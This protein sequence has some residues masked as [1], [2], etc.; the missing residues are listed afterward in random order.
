M[1]ECDECGYVGL[2]SVLKEQSII[3]EPKASMENSNVKSKREPLPLQFSDLLL[4]FEND[5]DND[6]PII[7][8]LVAADIPVL[9]INHENQLNA[10]ETNEN[11]AIA[12]NARLLWGIK[13]KIVVFVEGMER[14]EF[15]EWI[16]LRGITSCTSQLVMVERPARFN[17]VLKV[18]SSVIRF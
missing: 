9:V 17:T 5:I 11:T 18:N 4:L 7:K 2:W 1:C 8:I 6:T 15:A 12:A 13:R 16:K 3:M 10:L 14:S